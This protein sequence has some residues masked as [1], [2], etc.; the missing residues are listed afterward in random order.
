M[1]VYF[2]TNVLLDILM[3]SRT[4]HYE[5][6]TL[7][8]LA[9]KGIIQAVISTQSIIDA[10]YV[11]TQ[12]QKSPLEGFKKSMRFILGILTV[13]SVSENNIKAALRS[14]MN[15]FE[16]AAQLDCSLDAECDCIISS[17]RKL[18]ASSP[19][20]IYSPKEFCDLLFRE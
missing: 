17:D 4:Y 14:P 5:S 6:A 18:K 11:F 9:E 16:D 15:D 3:E 13:T 19:G 10:A 1:K 8:N 12:A 7:L 20:G 2:D